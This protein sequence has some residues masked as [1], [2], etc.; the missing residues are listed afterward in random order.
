MAVGLMGQIYGQIDP[1]RLGE[2]ERYVRVSLEYG[3][4]L[5]SGNVKSDTIIKLVAGYPSHEFVIDRTEA[6]ELFNRIDKPTDELE[7]LWDT[8]SSIKSKAIRSGES[9]TRCL[10]RNEM[11]HEH[12]SEGDAS[13]PKSAEKSGTTTRKDSSNAQ[14]NDGQVR[15]KPAKKRHTLPSDAQNT[16]CKRGDQ[17]RVA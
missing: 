3:S 11:T 1:S 17:S 5:Q 4:R 15:S 9:F 10:S 2:V 7:R 13:E 6:R 8:L 12:E 16:N 14:S